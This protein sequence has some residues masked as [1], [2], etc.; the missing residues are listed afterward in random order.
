LPSVHMVEDYR[1][2]PLAPPKREPSPARKEY[3]AMLRA[4]Y[5]DERAGQMLSTMAPL[6][7]VFPNLI[8]IMT[9]LRVVQPVGPGETYSYYYPVGLKGAPDEINE[10]RLRDH[11]FM[12]GAAGFVSPDDVE[13]MERN[14]IGM[15]AQ[16]N[17]WLFIGRGLHREREMPDGGR[18]GYTMDETHLRGFWRHYAA[19]MQRDQA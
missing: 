14:Q 19:L 17:D 13:I 7:Y 10:A 11:E 12:F 3:A 15:Q 4:K 5:G 16:G 6:L 8:Y 18:S 2:A 9:H 1:G